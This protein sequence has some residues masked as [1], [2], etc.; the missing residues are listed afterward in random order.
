MFL[1]NLL[2]VAPPQEV[3]DLQ[4]DLVAMLSY[5]AV[6]L[7]IVIGVVFAV[8]NRNKTAQTKSIAYAAICIALSFALSFIQFKMPYGG[9][10]TAVSMLPIILFAY[11]YGPVKGLLTGIVYGLLQYIQ[12]P[13]FLSL[14]QFLF[15]FI[16]AFSAIALAGIAKPLIKKD[17]INIFVG[18]AL[19]FVGRLAMHFSAGL[20]FFNLGWV[21][22]IPLVGDGS[23]S[24][25][26][27]YSLVYNSLYLVPEFL[28]LAAVTV[29]LVFSKS[30]TR[31]TSM[32]EVGKNR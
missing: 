12:A 25:G 30:F 2:A 8:F 5:I 1:F 15:D 17:N 13:Y 3:I 29:F 31:I 23:V 22:E 18:L 4:T 14:A 11:V 7:L 27:L 26:I 28:I 21:A 19:V 10:I 16:L 24:G 9:S 6:G 20:I 32:L